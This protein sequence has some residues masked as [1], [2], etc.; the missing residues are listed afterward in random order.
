MLNSHFK[1]LSHALCNTINGIIYENAQLANLYT[2]REPKT[3][4]EFWSISII[5]KS[6]GNA[7]KYYKSQNLTPTIK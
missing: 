2:T 3:E 4:P 6:P 5:A 7:D 1:F